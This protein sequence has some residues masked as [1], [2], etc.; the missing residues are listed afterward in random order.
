VRG[1]ASIQADTKKRKVTLRG[2]GR[3]FLL[4]V[5]FQIFMTLIILGDVA[6][7]VI[8]EFAVENGENPE[9]PRVVAIV[10]LALYS[11]EIIAKLLCFGIHGFFRDMWNVFDMFVVLG[12]AALF[13]FGPGGILVAARLTKLATRIIKAVAKLLRVLLRLK[14]M[15]QAA[16][17]K[18]SKNKFRFVDVENNLDLDLT[19][20]DKDLVAMGVPTVGFWNTFVRNSLYEVARFFK[21][22]HQGHFRVYNACPE[23]PYPEWPFNKVGGSMTCYKIQDHSPP[24][25]EQ[26]LTFLEDARQFRSAHE[27]NVIAIH[28]K[29]GKGRTGSL[30]CAWLLYAKKQKTAEKAL[31]MFAERRTDQRISRKLRGVETPSQIRYVNQLFEHLKR[32][33]SWMHSPYPP[34]SIPTPTVTLHELKIE[35]DFF[36]HPEKIKGLRVLVQCFES[37]TNVSEP[38]LETDTFLPSEEFVTLG[39]IVVKGDVRVAL[40][41]T[42]GKNFSAREAMFAAPKNFNKSKGLLAYFCFHTGFMYAEDEAPS[43][44]SSRTAFGGTFEVDVSEMDK[45]SKRIKTEKKDGRFNEGSSMVLHFSGGFVPPQ[46]QRGTPM[47]TP[48]DTQSHP[49]APRLQQSAYRSGSMSSYASN[50]SAHSSHSPSCAVVREEDEGATQS[51]VTYGYIRS[52]VT[53][54]SCARSHTSPVPPIPIGFDGQEKAPARRIRS[55]RSGMSG[56]SGLSNNRE[57]AQA[58]APGVGP[59]GAGSLDGVGRSGSDHEAPAHNAAYMRSK[60][61]D[62]IASPQGDQASDTSPI[63]V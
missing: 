19:Y 40:F 46:Q 57:A 58:P 5:E 14:P 50:T 17:S 61:V 4:S 15:S 25:M 2:K 10:T 20:I 22:N 31:E 48:R 33:D 53:M 28:C 44:A 26:F 12:S 60:E 41:A 30:C 56:I 45:A 18:V 59:D 49:V 38:A 32:T 27:E 13:D 39:D 3:R 42:K 35:G 34:P 21:I 16:K 51:A 23:M 9:W 11:V 47:V 29:A 63:A 62:S 8:E 37:D 36:A 55:P 43:S 54:T 7:F 1:K 6:S 24:R 52:E